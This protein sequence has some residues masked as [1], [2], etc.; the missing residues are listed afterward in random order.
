MTNTK[1]IIALG[2]VLAAVLIQTT[3]FQ[4]VRPFGYA[5]ALA[6]LMVIA[7]ARYLEPEQ[8]LSV[9]FTGGFLQDILGGAPL[10]LWASTFTLVAFLTLKAR[11]RE[12][13]GTPVVLLGVFVLT[14]I[15]QFTY[16]VLGTLFGQGIINRPGFIG[17]LLVPPLYNVILAYPIFW[18][19]KI[20]VRPP[21]RTWAA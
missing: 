1:V 17:D 11:D 12:I 16:A 21:E 8:A 7:L 4:H 5:P 2:L 6:M 3:L 15:G 19:V 13:A 10:G 18:L 9:A 14:F 20:T